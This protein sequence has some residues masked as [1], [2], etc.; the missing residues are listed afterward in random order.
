MEI[1]EIVGTMAELVKQ[2]KVKY[3]GLSEVDP[4][5][6]CRVHAVHPIS[7]LQTEYSLWSREQNV[8]FLTSVK[9]SALRLLP[10]AH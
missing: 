1:E 7:V 9:S 4:E 10:T 8:S 2:G 3:I 6:L 5:T